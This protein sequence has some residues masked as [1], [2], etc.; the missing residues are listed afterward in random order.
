MRGLRWPPVGDAV[1]AAGARFRERLGALVREMGSRDPDRH[2]LS[3]VAWADGL[4]FSCVAGTLR[5]EVP[6]PRELRSGLRKLLGGML[7]G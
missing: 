3:L 5:A 1:D 4:M 7:G 6:G 2:V